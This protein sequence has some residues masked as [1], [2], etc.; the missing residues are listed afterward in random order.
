M[1]NEERAIFQRL[2]D[3]AS[4]LAFECHAVVTEVNLV[5]ENA[6]GRLLAAEAAVDQHNQKA[7]AMLRAKVAK[8]SA[9]MAAAEAPP[10][11]PPAKE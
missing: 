3:R 10:P 7:A 2:R 1:T 6:E 5:L 9:K 8:R 4:R 11:A